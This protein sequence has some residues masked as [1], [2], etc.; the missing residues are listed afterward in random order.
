M[1]TKQ[2]IDRTMFRTFLGYVVAWL[3]M[4]VLVAMMGILYT[5]TT[6]AFK[7]GLMIFWWSIGTIVAF[8]VAFPKF[9]KAAIL[10]SK[11][12]SRAIQKASTKFGQV[13]KKITASN[14]PNHPNLYKDLLGLC[15]DAVNSGLKTEQVNSILASHDNRMLFSFDTDLS[16]SVFVY[17]LYTMSDAD[18]DEGEVLA[19]I[20]VS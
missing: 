1:F 14:E 8:A 11:V 15:I 13:I 4:F 7:W 10:N 16:K 2:S 18:A 20:T 5:D 19:T 3:V 17:L 12:E 6:V 9:M